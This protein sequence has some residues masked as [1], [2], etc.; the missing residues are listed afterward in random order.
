M[1]TG[2]IL[3]ARCDACYNRSSIFYTREQLITLWESAVILWKRRDLPAD[4]RWRRRGCRA[5]VKCKEKRMKLVVNNR[6]CNPKHITVEQQVCS[7]DIELLAV[8]V[9]PYYLPREFSHVILLGVYVPPST[10][11]KSA[12]DIIHTVRVKLQREDPHA[13]IVISGDFNHLPLSYTTHIQT[14]CRLLHK[15]KQDFGFTVC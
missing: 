12:C 6:W 1:I 8:S 9:C 2:T 15:R 14:I 4:L 7:P 11:G 3:L 13:F 10:N 5:G